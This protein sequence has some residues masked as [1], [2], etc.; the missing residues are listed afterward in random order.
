MTTRTLVTPLAI[1]AVTL[2]GCGSDK[3]AAAKD[4][5]GRALAGA[6]K[7]ARCMREQGL[8]FPDPQVGERGMIRIGPGPGGRGPS[9]EDPKTQ[10]A[11]KVC[12]KHLA[13]GGGPVADPETRARLQDA[14]VAYAACMRRNGVD[15]P[16]PQPGTG[17]ILVK[18]GDAGAPDLAS[19]KFKAADGEC[20]HHLAAVD[21]AVEERRR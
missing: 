12:G 8:D 13:Q 10:A 18:P 6:L 14:F 3:P 21:A 20:H 9:P 5:E 15:V 16:D 4:A 1:A 2:A 7:F 11:Q 19:P 17:A